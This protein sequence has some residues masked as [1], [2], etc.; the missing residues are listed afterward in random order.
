MNVGK[1]IPA[2]SKNLID[3]SKIRYLGEECF[4]IFVCVCVCAN[5]NHILPQ[6]VY[7][8]VLGHT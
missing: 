3:F 6:R 1:G 8:T 7:C 4:E 2:F 5:I